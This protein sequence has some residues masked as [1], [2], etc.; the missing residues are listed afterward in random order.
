MRWINAFFLICIFHCV[1]PSTD[2][3]GVTDSG[4]MRRADSLFAQGNYFEA[5]IAYERVFY[6]SE[7]ATARVSANLKKAEALKQIGEFARALDDL[8][9]SFA[10]RGNDSL[11]LELHYQMAFCAY[12]DGAADEAHITLLQL[13]RAFGPVRQQR[14]Y[15][16]EGLILSERGGWDDL[17]EHLQSW[18]MDFEADSLTQ[19]N[20]MLAFDEI[21]DEGLAG[22]S[23]SADRA[24]LW[25]TFIPGAG[26]LYAGEPGWAVLN[27]FSQ[28]AGLA[29]FG[30]LAY[31]GFYVAGAVVGLGA[32]QSF[33]FGGIKQAGELTTKNTNS[34]LEKLQMAMA[35]LLL[36]VA[37]NLSE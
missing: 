11:R 13:R 17:R 6:H 16:L 2:V 8:R 19:Q 29:G 23:R 37:D 34:H 20:T 4:M 27:A 21:L 14:L 24:R 33:Y 15:L 18:L 28:L 12:M 32:F 30:F 10:F 3:F 1:T 26:Q 35:H 31:N 9:R 22:I 36:H 5:S 25:S 7:S